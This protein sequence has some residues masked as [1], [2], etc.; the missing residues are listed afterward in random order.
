MASRLGST[1]AEGGGGLPNGYYTDTESLHNR[2]ND[3]NRTHHLTAN[4][5]KSK[6]SCW[7]D[8]KNLMSIRDVIEEHARSIAAI[9]KSANRHSSH[10]ASMKIDFQR[11]RR[12]QWLE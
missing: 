9:K 2:L 3:L 6:I 8:D 5:P 1:S 7:S 10:N 12:N 4:R 11:K